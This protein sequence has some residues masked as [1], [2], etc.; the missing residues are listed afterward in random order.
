MKG[1]RQQDGRVQ[2][3]LGTYVE[4]PTHTYSPSTNIPHPRAVMSHERAADGE[5]KPI[6]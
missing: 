5:D 3:G 6:V 1:H 2:N 4:T